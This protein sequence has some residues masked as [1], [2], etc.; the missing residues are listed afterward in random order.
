MEGDLIYVELYEVKCNFSDLCILFL[1]DPR[2]FD[3]L[4]CDII[5]LV[6]TANG[7]WSLSPTKSNQLKA[8][9]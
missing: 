7:Y 8:L 9:D 4:I 6:F 5:K 3:S 1:M 2:F